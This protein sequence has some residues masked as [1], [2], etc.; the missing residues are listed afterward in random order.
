MSAD[1]VIAAV[2]DVL[3]KGIMGCSRTRCQ[4]V[5]T[6]AMRADFQVGQ[7]KRQTL[8]PKSRYGLPSTWQSP[9]AKQRLMVL[10]PEIGWHDDA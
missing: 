5:S 4:E 8:F 7:F 10:G 1:R 9:R 2:K 6:K 3:F